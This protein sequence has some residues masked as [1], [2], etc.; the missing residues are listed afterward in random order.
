MTDS[1]FKRIMNQN[2]KTIQI[3]QFDSSEIKLHLHRKFGSI[4][5]LSRKGLKWESR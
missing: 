1:I 4:S 3:K 2:P 5:G